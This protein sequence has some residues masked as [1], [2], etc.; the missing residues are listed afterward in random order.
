MARAAGLAD[1]VG[2][3]EAEIGR[4]KQQEWYHVKTLHKQ[5]REQ[6]Q[7]PRGKPSK[8][9]DE[10]DAIFF[11][12]TLFTLYRDENSKWKKERDDY[13]END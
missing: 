3:A 8:E 11:I 1:L 12:V 10:V 5:S 2:K 4:E 9:D 7:H 6:E 13:Y